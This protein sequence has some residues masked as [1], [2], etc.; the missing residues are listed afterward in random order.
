MIQTDILFAIRFLLHIALAIYFTRALITALPT[1]VRERNG[2]V[3]LSILFGSL[4][5]FMGANSV[6]NLLN[7]FLVEYRQVWLDPF[8]WITNGSLAVAVGAAGWLSR[9]GGQ[10][11]KLAAHYV[12]LQTPDRELRRRLAEEQRRNEALQGLVADMEH[13]VYAA[14]HDLRAPLRAIRGFVDLLNESP[15]APPEPDY[16]HHINVGT[17]KLLALIDALADYSRVEATHALEPVD[18]NLVLESV[19]EDLAVV[20]AEKGASVRAGKLPVITGSP[21]KLYLV[22]QNLIDNALKFGASTVW[23]SAGWLDGRQVITVSD[24]GIGIAPEYHDKVFWIFQRLNREEDYP[25]T[26]M[27]LAICRKIIAQHGGQLWVESQAGRGAA[28]RFSLPP[29]EGQ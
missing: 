24:N 22:L 16:L 5:L 25:G 14:A 27:G 11:A 8:L 6:I 23:V 17:D 10:S 21:A 9:Y 4:A 15:D 29:R 12:L 18:L 13:F 2:S 7:I 19:L 26:G 1:A 3:V 20:I 28:F